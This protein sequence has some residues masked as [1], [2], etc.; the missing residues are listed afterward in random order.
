VE[1]LQEAIRKGFKDGAR[2]KGNG[3]FRA[4]RSRDDFKAVLARQPAAG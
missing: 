3:Q 1:L 4:L 2:L